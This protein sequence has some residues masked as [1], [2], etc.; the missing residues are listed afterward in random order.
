MDFRRAT[1]IAF[2][3]T[4]VM[5]GTVSAQTLGTSTVDTAFNSASGQDVIPSEQRPMTKIQLSLEDN[6]NVLAT[7]GA[8]G[9]ESASTK[10]PNGDMKKKANAK[11]AISRA[12]F[13]KLTPVEQQ[14]VL[15]HGTEI[16]E[17]VPV[18]LSN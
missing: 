7:E 3:F 9:T 10:L 13:E 2:L 12:H 17:P 16:T 5:A 1:I 4:F 8:G 6:I 18:D 14:A 11:S 15:D